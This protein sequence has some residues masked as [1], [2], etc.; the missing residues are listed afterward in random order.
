MQANQAL[1]PSLAEYVFREPPHGGRVHPIATA[2]TSDDH[3]LEV[4][5]HQLQVAASKMSIGEG[6]R[7]VEVLRRAF[8][9]AEAHSNPPWPITRLAMA[10]VR[11]S[12][13]VAL[14]QLNRHDQALAEAR[15]AKKETDE[16]WRTMREASAEAAEADALGIT[17]QPAPRLR[18][19]IRNP[20]TW[21]GKVVEIAIQ[22]RQAIA[23][24]LE[25]EGSATELRP[26]QPDETTVSFSD[27]STLSPSSNTQ[28]LR[29]HEIAVMNEEA[30]KLAKDLL[31][32]DSPIRIAAERVYQHSNT[33]HE[34]R[35]SKSQRS[36]TVKTSSP[37]A[38]SGTSS[39][40]R[41]VQ[42]AAQDPASPSGSVGAGGS[43]LRRSRS[44]ASW[45][46]EPHISPMSGDIAAYA[47]AGTM[48]KKAFGKTLNKTMSPSATASSGD[49]NDLDRTHDAFEDWRNA[50][51]DI[52]RM[53][54]SQLS[55]RTWE[56]QSKLST[57]LRLN[58]R[59]FKSLEMPTYSDDVLFEDG[60]FYSAHGMATKKR[61]EKMFPPNGRSPKNTASPAS[62]AAMRDLR[63]MF[64]RTM[65]E[66][67]LQ[68]SGISPPR[69][70]PQTPATGT[71]TK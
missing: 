41:R 13:C 5:E 67:A 63:V 45:S 3:L 31:P 47:Y 44:A 65:P 28:S 33:R 57:E 52:G 32:Q 61:Q 12:L 6:R 53:T 4:V 17:T 62:P 56:G 16:I 69:R 58:S 38:A 64:T 19:M 66:D 70:T 20:P 42:L 50:V 29:L 60:L 25:F 10:T 9:I 51:S 7:A 71:Q 36:L 22:A 1:K 26:Q 30:A 14:S 59:R 8:K 21:L 27:S 55:V 15:G 39:P 23:V 11:L 37:T 40:S 2:E 35:R 48:P 43:T 18:K 54:F 49:G 46:S 34:A 24:E 68:M